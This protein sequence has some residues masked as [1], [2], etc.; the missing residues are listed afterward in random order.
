LY[1]IDE[2]HYLP[3]HIACLPKN[4]HEYKKR[5]L[6]EIMLELI[7]CRHRYL[8]SKQDQN[9]EFVSPETNKIIKILLFICCVLELMISTFHVDTSMMT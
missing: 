7:V 2:I 6:V 1:T 5:E 3:I 8:M 9:S 4:Y